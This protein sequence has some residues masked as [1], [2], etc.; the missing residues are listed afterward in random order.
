MHRSALLGA[1]CL[2]RKRRGLVPG[3]QRNVLGRRTRL[4]LVK[5]KVR[6][7]CPRG[8]TGVEGAATD[9]GWIRVPRC[10]RASSWYLEY[11]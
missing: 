4:G 5:T 9:P 8:V 10:G 2:E 7:S 1:D 11:Y 6:C 3:T